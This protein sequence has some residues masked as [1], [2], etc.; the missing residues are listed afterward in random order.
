MK[1]CSEIIVIVA[2]PMGDVETSLETWMRIG[3]GERKLV[4]IRRVVCKDDGRTLPLTTVLL[5]YRNNFLSRW[6]IKVGI[7]QDPW[8]D[9]G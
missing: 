1:S 8:E 9:S 5:R 4:S 2:H 6:L 7:L 3:P